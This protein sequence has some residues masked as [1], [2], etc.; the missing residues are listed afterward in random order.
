[1]RIR[2][3]KVRRQCS[4]AQLLASRGITSKLRLRA[5]KITGISLVRNEEDLVGTCLRHHL[6]VGFDELVVIDNGSSD[7]TPQVLASFRNDSRV[8]W[9]RYDGP[10]V[11]NHIVSSLARE[12]F[13]RGSDWIVTF[14][15]DEFWY[16]PRGS[17]RDVLATTRAGALRVRFADFVQRRK[18]YRDSPRSLLHMTRRAARTVP[19]DEAVPLVQNNKLGFVESEFPAKWIGRASADF[20]IAKGSH[21]ITGVPEPHEDTDQIICLHAPIRSR[22]RLDQKADQAARIIETKPLPGEA[23]QTLRW[24]NLKRDGKLNEEWAANSYENDHLDVY[25]EKHPVIHD[26]RLR[27]LVAPHLPPWWWFDVLP[28]TRHT[29]RRLLRAWFRRP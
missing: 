16:A 13:Q 11:Q 9:T 1:M 2:Q 8:K 26:P 14:D 4:A 18:Q 5:M 25:G 19:Y 20:F 15:A 7:R 21:G 22:E 12:A 10:F 23:W 6:A 29:V 27:D 28:P 24:G 17:F 3:V